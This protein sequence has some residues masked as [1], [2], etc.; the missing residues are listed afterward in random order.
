MTQRAS[1]VNTGIVYPISSE[2]KNTS[3]PF[4]SKQELKTNHN[5]FMELAIAKIRIADHSSIFKSVTTTT[6]AIK[7]VNIRCSFIVEYE[8]VKMTRWNGSLMS[9]LEPKKM[10]MHFIAHL[11]FPRAQNYYHPVLST[12]RL[13]NTLCL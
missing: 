6:K 8:V 12:Q 3:C 9:F 5:I 1:F 2:E 4:L 10:K 11:K 7:L 13:S